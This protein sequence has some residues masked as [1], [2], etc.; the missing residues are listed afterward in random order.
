MDSPVSSSQRGQYASYGSNLKYVDERLVKKHLAELE[1]H[2]ETFFP[3][4]NDLVDFYK[5]KEAGKEFADFLDEKLL[6][7]LQGLLNQLPKSEKQ[8]NLE[9]A[10]KYAKSRGGRI[11]TK[12]MRS[13]VSKKTRSSFHN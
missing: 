8:E 7:P 9:L 3:Y 6:F 10:T 5:D 12:K 11:K 13:K 1:Q 2:I 4:I